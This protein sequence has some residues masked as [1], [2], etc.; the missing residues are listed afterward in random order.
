MRTLEAPSAGRLGEGRMTAL[1]PSQSK[2][3]LR[4]AVALLDG[5]PDSML[6]RIWFSERKALMT[7]LSAALGVSGTEAVIEALT[8]KGV[9]TDQ[10]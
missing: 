10:P 4:R 9:D 8:P 3:F 5:H 2:A 1:T 7:D 6:T